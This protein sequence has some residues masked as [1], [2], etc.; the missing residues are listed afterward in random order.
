M[1]FVAQKKSTAQYN[2]DIVLILLSSRILHAI[3]ILS[4]RVFPQGYFMIRV[5]CRY[6]GD[7]VFA[8]FQ[9]IRERNNHLPRQETCSGRQGGWGSTTIVLLSTTLPDSGF[10]VLLRSIQKYF[11]AKCTYVLD[12]MARNI[13]AFS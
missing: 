12:V 10:A 5:S 13:L 9:R 3:F 6:N 1:Y 7:S 4:F 2:H 11:L 8:L